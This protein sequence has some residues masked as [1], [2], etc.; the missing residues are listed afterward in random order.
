[1]QINPYF[2]YMK[3][4]WNFK[5]KCLNGFKFVLLYILFGGV[6]AGVIGYAIPA[7]YPN[8]YFS[9]SMQTVGFCLFGVSI[10][11]IIPLLLNKLEVI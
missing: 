9:Y 2:S 1:M 5:E 3:G 8:F 11:F 10:T 6:F 7:A 4:Y